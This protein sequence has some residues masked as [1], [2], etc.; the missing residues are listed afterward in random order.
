M[1]ADLRFMP[2]HLYLISTSA[3]D[4]YGF[5]FSFPFFIPDRRYLEWDS[6]PQ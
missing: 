6:S 4:N 5:P 2:L 1:I 3:N